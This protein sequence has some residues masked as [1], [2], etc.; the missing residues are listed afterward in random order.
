MPLAPDWTLNGLARFERP[1]T[2]SRSLVQAE[3]AAARESQWF[4]LRN[5]PVPRENGYLLLDAH[6]AITFD[7]TS[8][9][10]LALWGR[11]LSNE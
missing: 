1:T 6:A 4:D 3:L 5:Q 9:Y 11:N 7:T 2:A 8:R 10:E